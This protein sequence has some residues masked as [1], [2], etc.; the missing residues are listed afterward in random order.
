V[1][2]VPRLMHKLLFKAVIKAVL[3]LHYYS[4]VPLL[5]TN[6]GSDSILVCLE[7]C[8]GSGSHS[9]VRM[10]PVPVPVRSGSGVLQAMVLYPHRV[11]LDLGVFL[12]RRVCMILFSE[13]NSETGPDTGFIVEPPPNDS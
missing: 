5:T 1:A 11:I 3:K 12:V 4:M 7:Q 13:F 10:V 6:H 9:S 8:S 2:R